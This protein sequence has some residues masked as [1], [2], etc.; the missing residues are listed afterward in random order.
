MSLQEKI[1]AVERL[2]S[3]YY[4]RAP[5]I[6][7][8]DL[9]FREF[10]YQP[11]R[12]QS[13]VRHL[14]FR[15]RDEVIDF[16]TRNPP[17]H[18]YYSSATYLHPAVED[19]DAKG[20]RGSDLLF[21]IDADH[22]EKC[23]RS[24]W[25]RRLRICPE[26][27]VVS[28]NPSEECPQ[29]S[30]ETIDLVEP[31]CLSEA[32]RITRDLVDVLIEEIGVSRNSLEVYFSGNR[33]F[34]VRVFD[35]RFRELGRD[36]RRIIAEYVLAKDYNIRENI[37]PDLIILPPRISDGGIR[38]RIARRILR[39]I[40]DEDIRRYILSSGSEG[41]DI[42]RRVDRNKL[43]DLEKLYNEYAGIPIDTMV[44]IDI[45]R[46]VRI[47]NSINGKSGLITKKIDL[48]ELENFTPESEKL[49]PFKDLRII[50]EIRYRIPR[51]RFLERTLEVRSQALYEVPGDLGVFLE[52]KGLGRIR[53]VI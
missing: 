35:E 31:E 46:L 19:M 4:S 48:S 10:A 25:I 17:L 39:I 22:I 2:F 49:S 43:R 45:S 12:S 42:I 34:H 7:P 13:Y 5:L 23:V 50:I 3:E 24:G 33:G 36:E 47:P 32:A 38:S 30:G 11:F 52:L 53:K 28:E 18:L 37:D 20:W 21:D 40:E 15:T 27:G 8:E 41:L 26:C 6:L 1:S 9:E 29:C 16:F 14:S 51:I 44:T